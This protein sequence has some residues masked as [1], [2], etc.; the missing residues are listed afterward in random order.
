M[1]IRP[2][3]AGNA[4]SELNWFRS[5]WKSWLRPFKKKIRVDAFNVSMDRLIAHLA[6]SQRV[7]VAAGPPEDDRGDK[8]LGAICYKQ[9]GPD[10]QAMLVHW[11]YVRRT[12]RGNG[13]ALLLLQAAGWT[14]GKPIILTMPTS[15]SEETCKKWNIYHN[16]FFL[17]SGC[18]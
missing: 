2:L 12:Y 8:M 15:L 11:L 16:E 18:A 14:P 13:L 4:L 17:Y 9:L 6:L 3:A 10:D 1:E 5:T 7:L